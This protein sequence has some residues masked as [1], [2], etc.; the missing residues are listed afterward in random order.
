MALK[1]D[2]FQQILHDNNKNNPH[3]DQ[4]NSILTIKCNKNQAKKFPLK[5]K[6]N[7]RQ[8]LKNREEEIH[9][10]EELG[11]NEL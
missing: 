6:K 8:G 1:K 9:K 4:E 11:Q 3:E 2:I 5:S 10:K 7:S